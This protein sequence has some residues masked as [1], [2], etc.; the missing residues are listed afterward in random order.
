V[1]NRSYLSNYSAAIG[2]DKRLTAGKDRWKQLTFYKR[3]QSNKWRLQHN[4]IFSLTF[5][6]ILVFATTLFTNASE[7]WSSKLDSRVRFYQSTELG[8]LLVGTEKSL[9]AIDGASGEIVWRRKHITLDETDVAPIP[10]SDVLLLTVEDGSKTRLEATDITTGSVLWR[11][12]KVKG[13]VMQAALEQN[14]NLLAVVLV[15]DAKGRARDGFKRKP[16]VHMFDITSGRELWK[17]E[18]ES[19]IEMMPSRWPE[20]EGEK[21]PFTLNN[22]RPPLF[23][24]ERLY[25]FYEGAASLDVHTG[26]ERRREKFRINEEGLALTDSDPVADERALY[27]TGRG[28]VRAISRENGD[29]LW[30]T[31]DLGNVPELILTRDVLY[32]RTGGQLT[33][34]KD[35]ETVGKGPF[36]ISAIEPS[37]GK[38]LWRYKGADK[39]ITNIALVNS[40]TILL[41]DHDELIAID[42]STGKRRLKVQHKVDKAAFILLNETGQAVV[43]GPEDLA[44]FDPST[45]QQLWRA[46]HSPPR[47]GILRTVAA[48]AARATALYFRYGAAASFA[49]RGVQLV[50]AVNSLRLSGLA[51]SVSLPS[52]TTLAS[53]YTLDYARERFLTLGTLARVNRGTFAR[54]T[55]DVRVNVDVEDRLMDRLDPAHQLDRLSRFLL[56]RRRLASLRGQ[57]MYYYT[58]VGGGHGLAG[59]DI[60][61]GSV[62]RTVRINEPDERFVTDEASQLLYSS[63][64][65]RIL[66]YPLGQNN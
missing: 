22:Y 42:S 46:H 23:L 1:T 32:A 2:S 17:Y 34:L 6:L 44:S 60:N 50:N 45:G 30:E 51:N 57:Y 7:S 37:S 18:I 25:L 19:D 3:I 20:D 12:D 13:A 66:A 11:S 10:G 33:R 58:D 35:G 9:Y 26:K 38:I 63:H 39:G 40:S 27:T 29:V 31:K 55:V 59:V 8:L 54:P 61:T 41:A 64:D 53:N 36:G 16:A 5:L 4:S 47:R 49:F 56:H 21:V 48:I 52:L 62:G 15:R 43:G 28:R 14:S 24:D 65:N